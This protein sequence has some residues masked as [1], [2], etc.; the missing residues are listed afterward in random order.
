[1]SNKQEVCLFIKPA[2]AHGLAAPFVK[3]SEDLRVSYQRGDLL[4]KLL[5]EIP[6]TGKGSLCSQKGSLRC[7]FVKVILH[8]PAMTL[9]ETR[10]E[11]TISSTKVRK[12]NVRKH[13][14]KTKQVIN[15]HQHT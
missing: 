2:P 7:C 10:L 14:N 13:Q 9:E 3:Q 12:R 11:N 15:E 8:I 5:F 1:M 6:D 4:G